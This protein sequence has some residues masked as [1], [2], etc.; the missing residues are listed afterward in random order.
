MGGHLAEFYTRDEEKVVDQI[1]PK[2]LYFWIGLL[3]IGQ[4]NLWMWQE[5]NYWFGLVNSGQDNSWVWQEKNET[6]KYTNWNNKQPNNR[7]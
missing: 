2:S 1:L 4:D 3:D 6:P 7:G 5:N